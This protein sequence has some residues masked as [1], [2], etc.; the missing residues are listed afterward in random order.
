L[1]SCWRPYR[2]FFCCWADDG[3]MENRACYT[4][5]KP[6]IIVFTWIVCKSFKIC[7]PW[8]ELKRDTLIITFVYAWR[9]WYFFLSPPG[10]IKSWD[11]I[12]KP[13]HQVKF[14]IDKHQ[15]LPSDIYI[16]GKLSILQM[17]I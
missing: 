14:Y 9:V 6:V 2:F 12:W 13:S 16:C 5:M 8:W 17:D 4:L 7:V 1:P 11:I 15:T 3:R 10:F